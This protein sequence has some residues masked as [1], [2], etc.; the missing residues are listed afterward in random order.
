MSLEG[1]TA[2]KVAVRKR[3]HWSHRK[4]VDM[5]A[6]GSVEPGTRA[7]ARMRGTSK[8]QY[9]NEKTF[10][11]PLHWRGSDAVGQHARST[12]RTLFAT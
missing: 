5:G 1:D 4:N 10:E 7:P 12:E 6:L 2:A 9:G 11:W 3:N 8:L